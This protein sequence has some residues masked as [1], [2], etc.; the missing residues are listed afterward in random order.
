MVNIVRPYNP[1]A[2]E[3]ESEFANRL[4][5]LHTHHLAKSL[6]YSNICQN[7]YGKIDENSPLED[8]PAIPVSLFKHLRLASI[9]QDEVFREVKS[10]GT[11]G[12]PSLVVLDKVTS[13]LQTAA[14]ANILT[15]WLGRERRPMIL[16]DSPRVPGRVGQQSAGSAAVSA[17][18]M[19]GRDYFWLLDELGK[20]NIN[21]LT[22]WL[23]IHGRNKPVIFGFTYLVFQCFLQNEDLLRIGRA[24]EGATVIHGGG[25]KKLQ[26]IAVTNEDFRSSMLNSFGISE[27]RDYYGMA[28]QLGGIWVEGKDSVLIPSTYSSVIIRDPD[29]LKPVPKGQAGLIHSFSTLTLSYPGHSLLTDDIGVLVENSFLPEEFGELGLR[30]LARLPAAEPRGC[31]DATG[32]IA[33]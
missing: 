21:G 5:G 11:S 17:M 27:V 7:L 15:V 16:V 1:R 32:A 25:W 2:Q 6:E 28:E 13:R 8:Y 12:S 4:Y 30:V 22:E 20:P 33:E 9:S 14:L 26:D 29:T 18:M 31:S 3:R 24:L 19:F 23:S 10:S